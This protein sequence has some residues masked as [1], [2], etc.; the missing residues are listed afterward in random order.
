LQSEFVTMTTIVSDAVIGRLWGF[1][2]VILVHM[3][4]SQR[5][6]FMIDTRRSE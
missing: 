6:D 1:H 2:D 5:V 4:G 3:V